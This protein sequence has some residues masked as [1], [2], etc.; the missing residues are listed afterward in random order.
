[1]TICAGR[2][3]YRSQYVVEN[4]AKSH[5]MSFASCKQVGAYP[6]GPS[7]DQHWYR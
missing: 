4:A 6:Y 5:R 2:I 1:M 3:V 7:M